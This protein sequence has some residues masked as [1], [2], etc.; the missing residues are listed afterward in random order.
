MIA[1]VESSTNKVNAEAGHE[2][3]VFLSFRGP[4]SLEEFTDN[5]YHR[6]KDAGVQTFR[7]D[8]EL[9]VGEEI[10]PELMRAIKQSKISIP[11]FSKGYASSKW[12]LKEVAEMV[13]HKDETKHMILPI[14]LDV[15]P[16]EVQHQTGSYAEAFAQHEENYDF[17]T[18]Q[19]WRDALQKVV[20]LKG[21]ELKKEANGKHG[22]FIKKVLARVL[23]SL[24]NAYLDVND[25]LVGINHHV[26]AI[27]TTLLEVN[28]T[29]VQIVGIWGMGGIGKTTLAKVVFNQLL[30]QFESS[31]FLNDIRETSSQHKGLEYLQSKLVADILNSERKDFANT[32]EGTKQLKYRLRHK[33]A[34]I[35]LDEV[36]RVDQLKALAGDLAWFGPG[37]RI[38]ITT[39]EKNVLDLFQVSDIYELTLLSAD[40]AFELF[41]KHAFI[42]GLPTLDFI[43]LS[44]DIVSTTGRLPLALEVIGASLSTSSGRKEIWQGTLKQLKKK[45]HM[46]V[47]DTLKI[48]YDGLDHEQREIFLDIACFFIGTD[49]RVVKPMW[50]DCDFFPEVG[51][52]I[53]LLKSL[54]R[55]TDDS[56]LWMHDQLRDLGREIVERENYKEPWLRCRLWHSEV[57]MR[58]LE[59]HPREGMTK[60]EAISLE[61]YQFRSEDHCI[62]DDRFLHLTNLRILQLEKASLCGNFEL[63]L[64][65]L[66]W[67]SNSNPTPPTNLDLKS[68]IVLDLSRS[69]VARKLKVLDLTGCLQL[70]K[71]P[72][73][74]ASPA[75]ERLILRSCHNL[76]SIDPSIEKLS[77]L[78]SLDIR[79]CTS[80]KN[81]PQLGSMEALTELLVDGTSIRELPVLRDTDKLENLET[82]SANNCK[83][84]AQIPDSLKCL[85]KL[86]LL[87][88]DNCQSL[89]AVPDFIGQLTSLVELSLSGTQIRRLPDSIGN[90]TLLTVPKI[91]HSHMTCLPS[92]LATLENLQVLNASGCVDLEGDIPINIGSKS[93]MRI[94]Q[95]ADTKVSSLPTSISCLRQLEILDLGGCQRLQALPNLPSSLISLRLGGELIHIFPNLEHLINLKELIFSGCR[96]LVEVPMGIRNL[97]KLEKLELSNTGITTLPGAL[98]HLR[99]LRIQKCLKL[100]CLPRLPSSLY[101]LEISFCS[102]LARLPNLSNLNNLS[103]LRVY[104]SCKITEIPGLQG[105]T[106]LKRLDTSLCPITHLDGLER[107]DFLR[108][109]HI[110]LSQMEKLPN[111]SKLWRL[112]QMNAS[113]HRKLGPRPVA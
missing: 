40:Q 48:S 83:L 78:V 104:N 86:K 72:D 109:L 100:K 68:L 9:R 80:L 105:L 38:I 32:D 101:E 74:S 95:L 88:L 28:E 27:K 21:L 66:Q 70:R 65:D 73:F 30:D 43:D 12:C 17:E 79:N 84:L 76:V 103:L 53:L 25:I 46:K 5:L 37:S 39:R 106:S 90:L 10:G 107:L 64:P 93:S 45:P 71:T 15:T 108:S 97:S 49:A 19:V 20:K 1:P 42:K 29:G 54:I 60:V 35:L 111:P 6:L 14:F 51:I 4:D 47:R 82:L 7:D 8:E 3:E 13:K 36:D 92:T 57:A 89:G 62:E 18:V 2:Y 112:F 44:W 59:R 22:E 11:L 16:D 69:M 56:K 102:S 98:P 113:Y 61:G 52:E 23:I 24:R 94:L 85:K 99:E 96:Q 63:L 87:S 67:L 81:L 110:Q 33:K 26:E 31:C 55:I 58:A 34:I 41:C 50:D 77:A 91:D 75:L